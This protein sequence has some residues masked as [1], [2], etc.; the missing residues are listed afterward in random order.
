MEGIYRSQYW[1]KIFLGWDKHHLGKACRLGTV[2]TS[3]GSSNQFK[4]LLVEEV[5][6]YALET[7]N[8]C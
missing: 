4:C 8:I 3:R 1:E 6:L 7:L 2:K 5:A